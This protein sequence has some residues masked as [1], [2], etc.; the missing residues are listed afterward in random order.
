MTLSPRRN[1]SAVCL[2]TCLALAYGLT[3]SSGRLS[4]AVESPI[5]DT[6]RA[7]DLIRRQPGFS[8]PTWG[9]GITERGSFIGAVR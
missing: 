1:S 8:Y 5:T 9:S 2:V 6:A 3:H 4:P 7:H